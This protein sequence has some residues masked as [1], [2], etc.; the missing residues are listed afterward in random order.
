[1][2]PNSSLL[3]SYIRGT[4]SKAFG[5]TL[6]ENLSRHIHFLVQ[7]RQEIHGVKTNFVML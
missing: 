7:C 3:I 1:M 6:E 2:K 4:I 5:V